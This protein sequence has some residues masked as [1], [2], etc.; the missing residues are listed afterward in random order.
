MKEKGDCSLRPLISSAHQL[1]FWNLKR[2]L[3]W[4]TIANTMRWF[5]VQS[6]DQS[7]VEL[8][9]PTTWSYRCVNL[10]STGSFNRTAVFKWS[11]FKEKKQSSLW[12]LTS[13]T[14]QLQFWTLKRNLNLWG[15]QLVN[16]MREFPIR[17]DGKKFWELKV[18]TNRATDLWLTPRPRTF[19]LTYM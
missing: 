4:L 5:R 16:W 9:V 1:K 15:F 17:F 14:S 12:S 11:Y 3:L 18:P 7:V 13:S 10:I 2:P 19:T 6:N 8:E